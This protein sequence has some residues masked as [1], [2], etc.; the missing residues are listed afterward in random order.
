MQSLIEKASQWQQHPRGVDLSLPNYQSMISNF[1]QLP[2]HCM[3][4]P[5]RIISTDVFIIAFQLELSHV[6]RYDVVE[7]GVSHWIIGLLDCSGLHFIVMREH[8]CISVVKIM[9]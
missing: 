9:E 1:I 7:S 8:T 4:T 5:K 3:A 2:D 6:S